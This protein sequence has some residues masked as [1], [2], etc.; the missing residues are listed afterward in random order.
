MMAIHLPPWIW[1]AIAG[2]VAPIALLM[3]ILQ[4]KNTVARVMVGVLVLS[5]FACAALLFMPSGHRQTLERSI[6]RM[7]AAVARGDRADAARLTVALDEDTAAVALE[8]G[9]RAE[10]KIKEKRTRLRD[11]DRKITK[12]APPPPT[13]RAPGAVIPARPG[14][15]SIIIEG[16]G[17]ALRVADQHPQR[18]DSPISSLLLAVM[19]GAFL[20]VGYVFL[21][22]STRGQFTW[23]L[24]IA[25]LAAFGA[26]CVAME[27]LRNSL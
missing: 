17:Y 3:M 19:I 26:I 5:F 21:D 9:H 4:I 16:P 10:E 8:E 11:R 24:R 20:C 18:P 1:P 12:L 23:P 22:A 13:P 6:H 2:C 25:S 7:K 14:D 27:T 15:L